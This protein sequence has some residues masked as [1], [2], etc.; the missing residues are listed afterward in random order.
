M[1]S[2]QPRDQL[3]LDRYEGVSKGYYERRYLSVQLMKCVDGLWKTSF[4]ARQ[5]SKGIAPEGETEVVTMDNVCVYI[6]PSYVVNGRIRAE[7]AERMNLGIADAVA[8]GMTKRYV[9]K[10]LNP[11]NKTSVPETE[12][13]MEAFWRM[14]GLC[15]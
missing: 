11:R 5:L 15:P 9:R 4:V 2:I 12:S 10:Y 7:Y 6:S 14:L 13:R 1:F 8:L 3:I